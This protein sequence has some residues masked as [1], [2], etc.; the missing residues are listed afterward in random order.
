MANPWGWL[1]M[2]RPTS[3]YYQTPKNCGSS[4]CSSEVIALGTPLIYWTIT[5]ALFVVTAL[6]FTSRDA[7]A[8]L[9]LMTIAGGYLPWFLFQKRTMFT[10]YVISFEPFLMLL[11]IYLLYIYFDRAKDE[12]ELKKRKALAIAIGVVYA[13]NFIYF[14]PLYYGA[15][16]S[17]NSWFSHMWFASWI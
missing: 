15:T 3:F 13:I 7:K 10:F 2:A 4:S 12:R 1:F 11:L 8:G 16:I 6:W 14:M 5:V 9:I 17:Y